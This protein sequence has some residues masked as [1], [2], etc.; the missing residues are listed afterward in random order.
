MTA[1]AGTYKDGE[2][3]LRCPYCGDSEK[4]KDKA[5]FS[6]N[7]A[8]LYHCMRCGIGGKLKLRK[9]IQLLTKY[10]LEYGV[11]PSKKMRG[12]P[13]DKIFEDLMPGPGSTRESNLQRFHLMTP[14]AF[15]DVFLIRDVKGLGRGLQLVNVQ[16]NKKKILGK[17]GLGYRDPLVPYYDLPI[18]IVEGPYDV[19]SRG[20]VCTF[21]LP[22]YN[23][24]RGLKGISVVLC[25]DGDVW[26]R[27]Q[28]IYA[29]KETVKDSLEAGVLISYIEQLPP[30][31]DPGSTR[32]R[33][34]MV[35]VEAFLTWR[36]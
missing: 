18:R 21:G 25:P 7:G 17:K 27:P 8:G 15:F 33:G 35:P 26:N 10:G 13:W 16:T 6:V 12:V 11:V 31:E 32:K 34:K 28:L 30:Y 14:S 36:Y 29:L 3:W 22:S 23:L 4:H 20:D 19:L 24:L 9:Q 1:L 5:H 2:L